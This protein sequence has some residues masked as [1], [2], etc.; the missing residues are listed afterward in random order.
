[1]FLGLL[2]LV[3]T[4]NTKDNH[5]NYREGPPSETNNLAKREAIHLKT[6]PH[7]R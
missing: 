3:K 6:H 1:M 4:K 7:S 2:S 5:F